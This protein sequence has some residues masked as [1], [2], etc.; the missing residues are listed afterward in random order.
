M[1]P[2]RPIPPEDAESVRAGDVLLVSDGEA[3]HAV[4]IR[5]SEHPYPSVYM[6]DLAQVDE[7]LQ[8]APGGYLEPLG[9]GVFDPET[10]TRVV[11]VGQVEMATEATEEGAEDEPSE[12]AE[13]PE[14]DGLDYILSAIGG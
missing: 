13:F 1:I 5:R 3:A 12:S 14:D 4:V 8:G 6:V 7:A 10:A 11:R 2:W 9:Y